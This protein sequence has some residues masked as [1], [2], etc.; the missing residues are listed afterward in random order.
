MTYVDDTSDT[1]PPADG[2]PAEEEVPSTRPT[3]VPPLPL[4]PELQDAIER[5]VADRTVEIVTHFDQKLQFLLEEMKDVTRNLAAE[6]R[7]VVAKLETQNGKLEAQ[8]IKIDAMRE[9]ARATRESLEAKM[10][11]ADVQST[12]VRL[13]K[14]ESRVGN[15][16]R[17]VRRLLHPDD[18]SSSG[19]EGANGSNAHL[20]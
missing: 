6:I 8:S 16:Q 9:E 12:V 19:G 20:A 7:G 17:D 3:Q 11:A 2:F 18:N 10:T 5:A 15:L 1:L 4:A 14:L 13:G